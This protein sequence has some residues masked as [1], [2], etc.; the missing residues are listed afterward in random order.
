[1]GHLDSADRSPY[2]NRHEIAF[3]RNVAPALPGRLVPR[4]FEAVEV[5]DTS[6][7]H[8][9]LED[10]TDLHFIATR[11]RC[12]RRWN[13]ARASCRRKL[14]FMRHGGTIRVWASR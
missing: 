10:L 2:A 1:M 11:G 14:A 12:L 13:N 6:A 5:T 8:L 4:C 7:W 9:L 3:Y